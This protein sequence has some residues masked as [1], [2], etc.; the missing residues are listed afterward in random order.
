MVGRSREVDEVRPGLARRHRHEVDVRPAH[1][2]DAALRAAGADDLV[3]RPEAREPGDDAVRV[4]GLDEQ[5]EVADGL[6]A[7][8][9]RPR[10]HDPPDAGRALEQPHEVVGDRLG[11]VEQEALGARLEL[12]DA[13]ED[14]LLGAG[15]DALQPAE[16]AGLGGLAQV[17]ERLHAEALVDDAHGLRPDARDPQQVDEAGRD[18]RAEALVGRHVAGRRELDDLVPD[19]LAHAGDR[20]PVARGVGGR[21]VERRPRDGVGGAM[22]GDGLELDLALDLE[23]V[24]HLVE[25][26]GEVP[27]GRRPP[28]AGVVR[29]LVGV[30]RRLVDDGRGRLRR[31]GLAGRSGRRGAA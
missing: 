17:L 15:R 13:L 16:R 20:T 11:P 19:R 18:L 2:P 3:D 22:V 28:L 31:P 23:D 12:L 10:L 1:Q 30:S 9:K 8:A 26:P 27:V 7:P 14:P 5:V 4:V 29:R 6:L 21:D 25:D 24:A